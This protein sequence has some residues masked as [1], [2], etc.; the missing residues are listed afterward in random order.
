MS[1]AAVV[2]VVATVGCHVGRTFEGNSGIGTRGTL[3]VLLWGVQWSDGSSASR[4]LEA[5]MAGWSVDGE[6]GAK[7]PLTGMLL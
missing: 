2:V 6:G 4:A 3:L 5:S 1:A 7:R